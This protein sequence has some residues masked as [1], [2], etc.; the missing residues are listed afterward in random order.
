MGNVLNSAFV[1]WLLKWG[2]SK[3]GFLITAAVTWGLTNIG[4]D[5]LL[6]AEDY[7]SVSKGLNAGGIAAIAAFYAWLSERQ[8]R[9]VKVLQVLHNEV[10][11]VPSQKVAVDGVA[12]NKT[13]TKVA[14]ASELSP[15]VAVD[16]AASK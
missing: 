9:G 15:S 7:A 14:L 1:Q 5:K 13:I 6:S 8:K 10:T 2:L 4:I 3:S 12:G 16:I 11:E